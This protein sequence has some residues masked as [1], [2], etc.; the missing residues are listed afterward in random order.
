MIGTLLAQVAQALAQAGEPHQLPPLELP[1]VEYSALAPH[2]ILIGGAL[3]LLVW[4]AMVR[5]RPPWA[6][7]AFTVVVGLASLVA[8]WLLWLDVDRNGPRPAVAGAIAV[9]GYAVFFLVT[10]SAIVVLGALMGDAYLKREEVRGPEFYVLM[11]LSASGAMFMA[12]A[13]DLVITFLGLEVLSIALYVLAGLNNRRMESR[14]AAIKYFVLG[15]F[16]SAVFLYGVALIYGA[17]GSTNLGEISAYLDSTVSPADGVLLAGIALLLVGFGFKVA[18]VPFHT[19]TPDVYQGAPTPVTGFMAAGAKAAGF[20]GLLRVFFSTFDIL[21]LD[22]QPIVWILAVLTLLVGSVLAIV[23]EDIKRMLAYSSISH[24]GYVLIGLQAAND[25]GLAGSLYYLLTYT[26]M[27]MGSFAVVT[28]VGR[29]GDA[30]HDLDAYRGLSA[31][32]PALAMALTVLLLAQAGIPFTTGFLAKFYVISAAVEGRSYTLALI[33]ML[34]SVVAA[35]FYLRVTVLMYM[36][37]EEEEREETDPVPVPRSM[38]VVLTVSVAFTVAFGLL[39]GPVI[40]FARDA[41]HLL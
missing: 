37:S 40:D 35:F 5:R 36:S 29:R 4:V 14:E 1:Q 6:W 18:A 8:S 25:K 39:P 21:K 33:G 15:A 11:L 19:W 38:A 7:S 31:R 34:S 12:S 10:V 3:V 28:L 41:S 20:A 16:S 30:R 22:W 23:Q 26:F 24:A 13:N 2:L 27:V 9:D 32:R 17:T